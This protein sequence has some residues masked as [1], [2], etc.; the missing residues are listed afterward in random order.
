VEAI[1]S[2]KDR[3]KRSPLYKAVAAWHQRLSPQDIVR[4]VASLN[5]GRADTIGTMCT[6]S[7]IELKVYR[8]FQIYWEEIF[9]IKTTFLHQFGAEINKAKQKF[10][11]QEHP[12]LPVLFEE[13]DQCS[14]VSA[15]NVI[16]GQDVCIPSV[17]K[18]T[19]GFSCASE[20]P[21]SNKRE[22]PTTEWIPKK[23]GSTGS[24]I[25]LQLSALAFGVVGKT[26]E[27]I[28]PEEVILENLKQMANKDDGQNMSDKDW[29]VEWFRE[30]GYD[31]AWLEVEARDF[32]SLANRFRLF[33]VAFKAEPFSCAE[34]FIQ[35]V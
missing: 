6:G 8:C 11:I 21:L 28:N 25:Q 20:S 1:N 7:G 29:V 22:A 32:G 12:D 19:A 31:A 16:T 13:A 35:R 23:A 9:E 3:Y 14:K 33:L 2:E 30:H 15:S 17:R 27:S 5:L 26:I 34:R 4:L 10:I 24:L 18:L